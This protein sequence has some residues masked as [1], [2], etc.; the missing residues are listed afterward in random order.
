MINI[1][2][3][4]LNN[5][6]QDTYL[7]V[8]INYRPRNTNIPAVLL[9]SFTHLFITFYSDGRSSKF[10]RIWRFWAI[11]NKIFTLTFKNNLK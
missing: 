10:Q 8:F 5:T 3:S 7:I 2:Y 4:Y 9:E 6:L 1:C 11:S